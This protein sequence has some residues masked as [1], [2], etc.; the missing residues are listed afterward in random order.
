MSQVQSADGTVVIANDI[1]VDSTGTINRNPAIVALANGGYAIIY[2]DNEFQDGGM[3][4]STYSATGVFVAR[5]DI[6]GNSWICP[7]PR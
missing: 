2:E 5:F 6:S 1:P 4:M 7:I 3:T